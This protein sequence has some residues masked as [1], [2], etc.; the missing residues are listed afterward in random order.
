MSEK[1]KD[2]KDRIETLEEAINMLEN[3]LK[4]YGHLIKLN[5][6]EFIL[7]KIE[8]FKREL[9]IRKDFPLYHLI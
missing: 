5:T 8:A 9:K 1:L 2:V 3:H 6:Y 7:K 4:E